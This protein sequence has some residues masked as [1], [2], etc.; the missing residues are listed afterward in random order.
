M[1]SIDEALTT[2]GAQQM[3]EVIF[4][5]TPDPREI[6][7]DATLLI[8]RQPPMRFLQHLSTGTDDYQSHGLDER[9]RKRPHELRH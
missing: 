5:R 1:R 9:E 6:P 3:R 7:V 8:G 2:H 4:R